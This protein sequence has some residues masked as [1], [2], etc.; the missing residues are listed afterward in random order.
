MTSDIE[1]DAQ[2]L[3][4][5]LYV[6]KSEQDG[7]MSDHLT[8][9]CNYCNIGSAVFFEGEDCDLPD[10]DWL[11]KAATHVSTEHR[12]RPHGPIF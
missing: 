8:A 4:K 12:I 5:F 6:H 11:V 10:S 7:A 1:I 9:E 3:S 2:K